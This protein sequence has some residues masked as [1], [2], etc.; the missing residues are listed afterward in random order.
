[1]AGR[2]VS[3]AWVDSTSLSVGGVRLDCSPDAV[4]SILEFLDASAPPMPP[5]VQAADPAA[6]AAA[7]AQAYMGAC[8]CAMWCVLCVRVRI[9]VV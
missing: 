4:Q 9:H 2:F 8:M 7:A 3:R 1:M 5:A 6:T